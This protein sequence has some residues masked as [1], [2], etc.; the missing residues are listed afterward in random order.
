MYV[1]T[2]CSGDVFHLLHII[3]EPAMVHIW[4]GVY[5]PPDENAELLEVGSQPLARVVPVEGYSRGLSSL[6]VAVHTS[7]PPH[8]SLNLEAQ[9]SHWHAQS[10]GVSKKHA[11]KPSVKQP[12]VL[13]SAHLQLLV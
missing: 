1:I 3:P 2:P 9:N 13:V 8:S 7:W 11:T 6:S 12:S 10:K 5:V 4:A